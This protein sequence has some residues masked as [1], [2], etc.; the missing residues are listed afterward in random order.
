MNDTRRTMVRLLALTAL[1][2]PLA[3]GQA[4]AQAKLDGPEVK[5]GVI[6]TVDGVWGTYGVEGFRGVDYAADDLNAKGGI[7]G[8]K[9]KLVKYD[10]HG[11]RQR[12]AEHRAA[13]SP[14]ST[15]YWPSSGPTP[16]GEAEIVFP[17]ANQ[18]KVP[19]IGTSVAKGGLLDK[20]RPWAFRNVMP[21]DLNTAPVIAKVVKDKN[22]KTAAVIMDVKD[23]VSKYM[24]S[25]FWPPLLPSS[26]STISPKPTR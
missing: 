21:D 23:A 6:Y 17:I 16:R 20:N 26:A 12:A 4:R 7:G 11:S 5:I 19:V 22:I 3:A 15:T 18:L 25:V 8:V 14:P 2:V 9:V 10:N 1:T 24:G 13:S